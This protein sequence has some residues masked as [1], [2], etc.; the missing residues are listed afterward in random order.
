MQ[1]AGVWSFL[2][3]GDVVWVYVDKPGHKVIDELVCQFPSNASN[4]ENCFSK[5]QLPKIDSYP[6]FSS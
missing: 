3:H 5:I 1:K 6:M 2:G 4:L